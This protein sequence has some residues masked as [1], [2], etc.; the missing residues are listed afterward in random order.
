M[1]GWVGKKVGHVVLYASLYAIIGV[2]GGA[3]PALADSIVI[4]ARGTIPPTCQITRTRG[5]PRVD[6]SAAGSTF[7]TAAVKC[8]IPFVVKAQSSRG[9]FRNWVQPTPTATNLLPY[10]LT[11][12][13]PLD[14]GTMLSGTCASP[15]L[16]AGQAGCGLSPAGAGLPSGAV[17]SWNKAMTLTLRW[18]P[19]TTPLVSGG[20]FTDQIIV[21]LGAQP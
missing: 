10:D 11:M 6:L 12:Q 5:Y 15:T 18:T 21:T 7:A 8:N 16:V 9:G 14:N 4:P 20:V 2:T 17:P 13:L 19:S 3:A 1:S